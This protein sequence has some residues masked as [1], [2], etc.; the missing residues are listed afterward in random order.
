[1]YLNVFLIFIKKQMLAWIYY[2]IIPF[3]LL[4]SIRLLILQL[5]S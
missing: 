1:M 5:L 4:L 2:V 3:F